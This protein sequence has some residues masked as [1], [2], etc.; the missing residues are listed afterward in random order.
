MGVTV[1]H[2]ERKKL[3]LAL[4]ALHNLG[5]NV[6]FVS[7]VQLA[8]WKQEKESYMVVK[9]KVAVVEVS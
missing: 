7:V 4:R 1:F 8:A 5:S 3:H 6:Q 2:S 9:N